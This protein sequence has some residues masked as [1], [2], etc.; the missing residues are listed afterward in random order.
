MSRTVEPLPAVSSPASVVVVGAGMAGLCAA[1]ELRRAGC[2]VTVLEA[3]RTAG[4]RVRTRRDFPEGL[5]VEE[6]ATRFP[7][8]HHFT[9]HYL[10]EFRLPLIPFDR[11]DMGHTLRVMG[12][13][14]ASHP[15]G[16]DAWPDELPLHAHERALDVEGL[17]ALYVA[18]LLGEIGDP[19]S[20]GWPGQLLR[21]RF[22]TV[23]FADVLRA[24]GASEGA[25]RVLSLG[26]HVGEGLNS[27]S[28]LWWLEAMALDV[29]AKGSVK[30]EGGNDRLADAFLGHLGDDVLF[31]RVVRRIDND[32]TGVT[33][34]VDAPMGSESYRADYAICTLPVPLTLDVAFDPDLTSARREAL[35][36]VPY[37][38]LSRVA[39]Q[40]RRRFWLDLGRSGFEDTDEEVAEVWD[41]TVGEP[42]DRGVLVAYS[43]GNE[44]RRVTAMTDQERVAYTTRRLER[45]LPGL[46]E[47]VEGGVS[48]CWD[49]EPWARGG[50][51]WFRPGQ[52]GLRSVIAAPHGRLHFAG[53]ATSPWPGWVQGAF[54]SARRAAREVLE[55]SA[56]PQT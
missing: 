24:K 28:A 42:G 1:Y 21:E 37:A 27:V 35:V 52:S 55:L 45:L 23:G 53:E 38:S 15:W 26:F 33:V 44:A 18:P 22:D 5:Y 2:A 34:H 29:G 20:P 49:A 19:L 12:R 30:V 3:R 51:A 13:D 36:A 48:M 25:I 31:G 41:L 4:G 56:T 40:C 39:L 43:G 8:A 46:S 47:H 17:H 32:A 7:V 16:Q 50:G 54:E 14:V 9:M 10:D 6:G 11:P